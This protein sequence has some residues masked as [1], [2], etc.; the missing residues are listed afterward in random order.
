MCDVGKVV[1][2]TTDNKIEIVD[3]PWTFDGKR[4]L[5]DADCL[6]IVRTVFMDSLFLGFSSPGCE[7]AMMVDE[8]FL[9]KDL[10][11]NRIASVLYGSACHGSPICG[12]VFFFD[13]DVNG[14]DFPL[15][16]PDAIASLL[17]AF[18]VE[19]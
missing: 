6:E 3:I 12:D 8:S 5:I 16:N 7:V 10:P 4:K 14:M 1:R 2:V 18:Y 17:T 13:L 11:I 19:C 15:S 9:L